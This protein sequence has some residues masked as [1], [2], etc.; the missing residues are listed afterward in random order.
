MNL[1]DLRF[2]LGM[3]VSRADG[4]NTESFLHLDSR[5]LRAFDAHILETWS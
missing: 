5:R 3:R 1:N 4:T 2:L